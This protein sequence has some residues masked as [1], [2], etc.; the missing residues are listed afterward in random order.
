MRTLPEIM[1]S[2]IALAHPMN[3]LDTDF[4]LLEDSLFADSLF[5]ELPEMEEEAA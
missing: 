4:D 5:Y 2:E 1:A 3:C